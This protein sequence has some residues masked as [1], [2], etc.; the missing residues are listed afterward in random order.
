MK[1]RRA[2]NA[3]GGL[4]AAAGAETA[5]G[6]PGPNG[7]IGSAGRNRG[8][9]FG[10]SPSGRRD[11][12][13][14]RPLI[15]SSERDFD[16]FKKEHRYAYDGPE[17]YELDDDLSNRVQ[18]LQVSSRGSSN[19]I[20]RLA[21]DTPPVPA[22]RPTTGKT[23]RPKR[24]EEDDDENGLNGS[25]TRRTNR[26]QKRNGIT[27]V[28]SAD[29][30]DDEDNDDGVD[31]H[32]DKTNNAAVNEGSPEVLHPIHPSQ[33]SQRIASGAAAGKKKKKRRPPKEPKQTTSDQPDVGGGV[34]KVST[35][36]DEPVDSEN[37]SKMGKKNS[38]TRELSSLSTS[39]E[40]TEENRMEFATRPV[41]QGVTVKCRIRRDRRGVDKNMFPSYY[42]EYERDD[43]KKIF[44]MAARK[45]KK[46]AT[47]NYLLSTDATD[48][49]RDGD[50]FL[51]KVRSN[52]LGTQFT[53]FDSGRS[54][55]QSAV[56]SE[57]NLR[58]ELAG[59]V[60][61]TNLLGLKGP[62][63]MTVVIPAM[64]TS[65]ERI[66]FRP[67]S[68]NDGIVERWK[69]KNMENLL[70]LHN[71]SPVWNDG[72]NC[73][74]SFFIFLQHSF[75]VSFFFRYTVVCSQFSWKSYTSLGQKFSNCPRQRW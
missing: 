10:T 27:K 30:D 63:K 74:L 73:Q 65:G 7:P 69:K 29:D 75:F 8:G 28:L 41:P 15:S 71:K 24:N 22:A 54:P 19:G 21:E 44:I 18:V 5:T 53:I 61:E 50:S 45:R 33:S 39:F 52:M 6:S 38:M 37:E 49:S 40:P 3:S 55:K 1:Q 4:L 42:L 12:A 56:I 9:N 59:V 26:Q 60:Y 32:N 72:K 13:E 20:N 16:D 35:D 66:E 68:E 14:A 25:P 48:L 64:T 46:S 57:D 51:G 34:L 23:R 58:S 31:Q 2:A 43:G 11:H 36:E 67:L 70:E 62:R 17:A 47:S